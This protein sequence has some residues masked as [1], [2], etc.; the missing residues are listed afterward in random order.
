LHVHMNYGGAYRTTPR[1]LAFQ[2]RAEDLDLVENLIVNKECRIPDVGYPV[3]LDP[4]STSG[5]LIVH[6]QEFH[7]SIW[8]HVGLL[9]LRD[10]VL[11][12]GYAGYA[13]TAASG[14]WPMNATVADLARAQGAVVGYVHPFDS[15]PAPE[16][17]SRTL[18]ADFP[19]HLALGQADS[20][21]EIGCV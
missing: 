1:R 14:R 10:H 18:T 9:G 16:D 11:L 20:Y 2:A 13:A 21:E 12:P 7:T 6:D 5:T 4:V 8:G 17:T 3:G 19:V 15:D